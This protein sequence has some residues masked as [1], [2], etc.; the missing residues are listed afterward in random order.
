LTFLGDDMG[1]TQPIFRFTWVGEKQ[2]NF[3]Q[4]SD[5]WKI[6]WQNTDKLKVQLIKKWKQIKTRNFI[7]RVL[8]D[9]VRCDVTFNAKDYELSPPDVE[10]TDALFSGIRILTNEGTSILYNP[11]EVIQKKVILL[12][13]NQPKKN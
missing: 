1:D 6:F 3:W 11:S 13:K 2:Q 12:Q 5:L 9:N 7:E 10:K 4:N 8:S